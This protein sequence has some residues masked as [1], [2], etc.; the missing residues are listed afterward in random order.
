MAF[1][2]SLLIF[3]LLI[4]ESQ[5]ATSLKLHKHKTSGS[6]YLTHLSKRGIT[7]N[8]PKL[9][10]ARKRD[11]GLMQGNDGVG[12]IFRHH[13]DLANPQD[14]PSAP[15]SKLEDTQ[16]MSAAGPPRQPRRQLKPSS[17]DKMLS[18]TTILDNTSPQPRIPTTAFSATILPQASFSSQLFPVPDTRKSI[19]AAAAQSEI[20]S[21]DSAED[22]PSPSVPPP[23]SPSLPPSSSSD[24]GSGE[25]MYPPSLS[26]SPD[27]ALSSSSSLPLAASTPS[28][29]ASS[30]SA[31]TTSS[32]PPATPSDL[33]IDLKSM[34]G[35]AYTVDALVGDEQ[36]P[37]P[38]LVG[39]PGAAV[40]RH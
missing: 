2:T 35:I 32:P 14:N 26:D 21:L 16:Q 11:L 13:P 37:V 8:T 22:G 3:M 6:A 31:A 34:F 4:S 9:H 39:P 30:P 17:T 7:P 12:L 20:A 38:V 10:A 33:S 28:P 15:A 23:Q 27:A 1:L 18:S 40:G 25:N 29:S 24:T 36:T 5:A 19:W